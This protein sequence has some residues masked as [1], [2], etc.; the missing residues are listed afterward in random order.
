MTPALSGSRWLAAAALAAAAAPLAH[1][2]DDDLFTFVQSDRLEYVDDG[3]GVLW[4]I[5]GWAGTDYHK[6]W[7]KAEGER[8]DGVTE[9]NELQLLYSRAHTP[10]FDLQ[11]GLRH[12]AATG[13]SRTHL[14][15]GL[16]GLAPQ[17]FE[18]DGALFLSEDGDWSGRLEAEYDLL[19]TQ[20]LV[21]QP[22]LELEFAL[23]DAPEFGVGSGLT[24]TDLSLRLRYELHRKFAPYVGVAWER[25]YGGTARAAQVAGN[26]D[27]VVSLV[28]GLRL[29]F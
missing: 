6:L 1:A 22:R 10:F 23:Q 27:D 5:Q 7:A 29:W 28:A 2:A 15:V 17:W 14:V 19:L 21:L 24:E 11:V 9:N 12:D 20:R 13:P 8:F 3:G 4:D 16:Q 18:V 25:L 26:D